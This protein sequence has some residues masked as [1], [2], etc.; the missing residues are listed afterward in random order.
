MGVCTFICIWAGAHRHTG[1][2]TH[3]FVHTHAHTHPFLHESTRKSMCSHWYH[4][5]S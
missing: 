1:T 5:L 4:K 2:Q 3:T